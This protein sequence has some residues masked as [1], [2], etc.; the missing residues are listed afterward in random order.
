MFNINQHNQYKNHDTTL[1]HWQSYSKD[2]V[3]ITVKYL[4][5]WSPFSKF[6]IN[7]F[8]SSAAIIAKGE[9][10]IV[11]SDCEYLQTTTKC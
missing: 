2:R 5:L 4:N 8:S 3:I 10:A 6:L 1:V 11:K 9:L 7:I